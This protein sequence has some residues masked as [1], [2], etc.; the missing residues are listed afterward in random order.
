MG[1]ALP[2]ACTSMLSGRGARWVPGTAL[3]AQPADTAAEPASSGCVTHCPP[4]HWRAR[5]RGPA[6]SSRCWQRPPPS[7]PPAPAAGRRPQSTWGGAPN[8][9]P[10]NTVYVYVSARPAAARLAE[11]CAARAVC[12][13]RRACTMRGRPG[14]FTSWRWKRAGKGGEKGAEEER[15]ADGVWMD[16]VL[17]LLLGRCRCAQSRGRDRERLV[18]SMCVRGGRAWSLYLLLPSPVLACHAYARG[19]ATART[20]AGRHEQIDSQ[21]TDNRFPRFSRFSRASIPL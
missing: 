19:R 20:G 1:A 8:A 21:L 4:A 9:G 7:T 10:T 5:W 2:A 13:S 11:A 15:E 14:R 18:C 6:P 3:R 12:A 17:R 16:Y